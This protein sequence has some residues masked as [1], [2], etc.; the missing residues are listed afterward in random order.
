MGKELLTEKDKRM[1]AQ[2]RF[3]RVRWMMMVFMVFILL[4]MVVTMLVAGD[5]QF[6]LFRVLCMG[7]VFAVFGFGIGII[8]SG[9]SW[10]TIV[11]KL[12]V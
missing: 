10:L 2:A 5:S 12:M 3:N 1:I 6:E 8:V 9:R 7:Y 4:Y 11:D